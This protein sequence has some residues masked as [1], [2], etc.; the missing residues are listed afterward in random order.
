VLTTPDSAGARA[1]R[2]GSAARRSAPERDTRLPHTSRLWSVT[3]GHISNSASAPTPGLGSRPCHPRTTKLAPTRPTRIS[4]KSGHTLYPLTL[5]SSFNSSI[6]R[7]RFH[8]VTHASLLTSTRSA[9][10]SAS[11]SS[12]NPSAFSFRFT[13]SPPISSFGKSPTHFCPFPLCTLALARK[14]DGPFTRIPLHRFADSDA[15]HHLLYTTAMGPLCHLTFDH[16]ISRPLRSGRPGVPAPAPCFGRA[17]PLS[18]S[19]LHA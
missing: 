9:T 6:I 5:T 13:H 3:W 14:P 17:G 10:S 18:R 7:Q 11:P 1:S 16:F 19:A 12:V 2:P 15:R 4:A 8:H